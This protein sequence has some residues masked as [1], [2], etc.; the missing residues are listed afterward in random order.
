MGPH[1]SQFQSHGRPKYRNTDSDK[2]YS[3]Y[4]YYWDD[5]DGPELQGWWIGPE[6]GGNDVWI[7]HK[8]TS[9]QVPPSQGWHAPHHGPV[10][11]TLRVMP[12]PPVVLAEATPP[13]GTPDAPDKDVPSGVAIA[14]EA[15]EAAASGWRRRAAPRP[16]GPAR[17]ACPRARRG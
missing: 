2:D 5:R 1:H 7:R 6:I 8:D 17:P 12:I 11:P 14:V 13:G 16:R 10:A 15:P 4:L 3:A 9:A